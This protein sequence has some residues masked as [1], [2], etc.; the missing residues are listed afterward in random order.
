MQPTDIELEDIEHNGERF[1]IMA[2][3]G[4]ADIDGF[5]QFARNPT[6]EYDADDD[7][8]LPLREQVRRSNLSFYGVYNTPQETLDN[9]AELSGQDAYRDEHSLTVA[10]KCG[11]YWRSIGIETIVYM[12]SFG[13]TMIANGLIIRFADANALASTLCAGG[14]AM[15]SLPHSRILFEN[16]LK[17]PREIIPE[18]RR[19]TFANVN[20]YAF[21][22]IS[23]MVKAAAAGGTLALM[24]DST[25][26]TQQVVGALTSLTVAPVT[27]SLRTSARAC[28][29]GTINLSPD[30]PGASEGFRTAYS[31]DLNPADDGRSYRYGFARDMFN[32]VL[33]VSGATL[34]LAM[35]NGLAI[36]TYCIGGREQLQEILDTTGSISS[37]DINEYCWGG[38]L[39]FL[40]RELGYTFAYS[41]G[42]MVLEPALSYALNKVYDFFYPRSS[43]SDAES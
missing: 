24:G 11:A 42:L 41:A 4:T 21:L 31:A 17:P 20:K 15:V 14:A 40:S 27:V 30:Y 25:F 28:L 36:Q 19:T 26:G 33:I 7:E 18:N 35:T 16:L 38:S 8:E 1:V 13:G 22:P 43:A 37:E 39:T 9:I 2:V 34:T 6:F 32:R 3:R 5:S 29:G 12:S 23:W 10:A